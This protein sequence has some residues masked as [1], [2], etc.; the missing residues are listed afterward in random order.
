MGFELLS[1]RNGSKGKTALGTRNAEEGSKAGEKERLHLCTWSGR[2]S[3]AEVLLV[4]MGME[5]VCELT[6]PKVS[7]SEKLQ[8]QTAFSR[9]LSNKGCIASQTILE[10]KVLTG[11]LPPTT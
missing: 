7:Y 4:A 6:C 3:W 8:R 9:W 11:L 2:R 10:M 5:E 1:K